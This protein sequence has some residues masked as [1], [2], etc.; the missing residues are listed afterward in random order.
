M[1]VYAKQTSR[2]SS[3]MSTI[4][5]IAAHMR[6]LL[7]H[8][9]DEIARVT[10][11]VRRRA[12]PLTAARFVQTLVFTLLAKPQAAVPDYCHPAAA[13]GLVISEQGCAQNFTAHAAA[14]LLGVLQL[15]AAVAV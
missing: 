8:Q 13:Q 14:V 1:L 12:K 11:F 4:P 6:C 9:A 2:R 15:V 7:T 3:L 10:R 5:E